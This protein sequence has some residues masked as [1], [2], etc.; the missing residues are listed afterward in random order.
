MAKII[1]GLCLKC[2]LE[3]ECFVYDES[4]IGFNSCVQM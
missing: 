4:K 2:D 1:T 3:S